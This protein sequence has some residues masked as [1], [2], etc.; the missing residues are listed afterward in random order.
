M[1]G[2]PIA[3]DDVTLWTKRNAIDELGRVLDARTELD[4][5]HLL[6]GALVGNVIAASTGSDRRTG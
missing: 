4:W 1:P 2:S 3:L 6:R 5:V